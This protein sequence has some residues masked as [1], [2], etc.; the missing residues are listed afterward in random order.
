MQAGQG[1]LPV[2]RARPG[3]RHQRC[4]PGMKNSLYFYGRIFVFA[5]TSF[6]F[7]EDKKSMLI[8]PAFRPAQLPVL[9]HPVLHGPRR[10]LHQE[11]R[12][13]HHHRGQAGTGHSRKRGF[14]VKNRLPV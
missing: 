8:F 4:V 13:P 10:P 6:D 14:T 11:L 9:P 3:Y 5:Q 12:V 7:L 2:L 1:G